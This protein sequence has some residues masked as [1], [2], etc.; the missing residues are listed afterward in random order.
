MALTPFLT[1]NEV[2]LSG[3]E[4]KLA[5]IDKV[6]VTVNIGGAEA[7]YRA[8]LPVNV[9]DSFGNSLLSWVQ[10]K[11]GL[12]DVLVPVVG[13]QPSKVAPVRVTL[14]GRPA[15]GYVV[16]RVVT[17]PA[18][19]TVLGAQGLLDN[20][21]YIYTSAVN[22]D[23]ATATITEK[24]TLLGVD[25][26]NIDRS[27]DYAAMVV[28]EREESRTLS[29]VVV[30]VSNGNPDYNYTLGTNTVSVEV[31]GAASAVES[32]ASADVT[33]SV[34]VSGLSPGQT[35]LSLQAATGSNVQIVAAEPQL[36]E[37]TVSEK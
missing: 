7:N 24:V 17:D 35:Y 30:S 25:G 15:E 26:L 12:V 5:L 36:I 21:D 1:P 37:V 20:L 31:R 11:P 29:D 22:I 28:I 13:R 23:G 3:A 32:I 16:S 10:V 18:V 14:S 27:S 6:F 2:V 8:S 34:D 4:D 9:L 19:V 33:A